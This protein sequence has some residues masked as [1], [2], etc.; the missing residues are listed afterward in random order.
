MFPFS[1]FRGSVESDSFITS[2]VRGFVNGC[3]KGLNMAVS[4]LSRL[5]GTPFVTKPTLS[6]FKT[7]N[8][9][10]M[11]RAIRYFKALFF[12]RDFFPWK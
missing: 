1:F 6:R 12:F 3:D 4:N 7:N 8:I 11:N 10:L 2:P 9:F 5:T